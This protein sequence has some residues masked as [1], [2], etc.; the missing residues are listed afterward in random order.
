MIHRLGSRKV[1]FFSLNMTITMFLVVMFYVNP[2]IDGQNGMGV[3]AL[4][5][6]FYKETGMGIVNTWGSLGVEHFN[7]GIFADYVYALSYSVFFASLLSRLILR[8]G[9]SEKA[10]YTWVIYAA[11]A[12]GLMDWI[13]N[14]I[15]IF[16]LKSPQDFS[17][18]LFFIHSVIST[19]K[20]SALPIVMLYIVVLTR[21]N[22][23]NKEVE[24][25]KNP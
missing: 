14:T 15:E 17:A 18:S 25:I 5:L 12:A 20:W 9:L 8:K 3:I 1:L 23:V 7:Q 21:K 16:F 4:Q 6:S 13:E 19:I 22:D 11:F 24:P 10:L 2:F